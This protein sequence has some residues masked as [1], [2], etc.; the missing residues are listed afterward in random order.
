MPSALRTTR[1]GFF[2]GHCLA[3]LA[4]SSSLA[5]ED[6]SA[7]L[8]ADATTLKRDVEAKLVDLM[9]AHDYAGFAYSIVR[10]R[11]MVVAGGVGVANRAEDIPMTADAV[12]Q[13]GS[14]TKMFTGLL[15]ARLAA[16]DRIEL[17][18]SLSDSWQ[19]DSAVPTDSNERAITLQ[20]LAT[21]TS[22]L[23][24]Y[25]DNLERVDGD[26]ILG[27]SVEELREGLS[28]V[29]IDGELPRPVNYSNF[30]YGVLAE[31]LA[32]SQSSS[33]DELLRQQVIEPLD[34][35]VTDFSLSAEMR[36]RLATPYRD[37]D[38]AVATVPW[39]MG[40]MSAAGGLFS[41]AVDLGRFAVWQLGGSTGAL[42]ERE[43]EAKH[44]QRAPLF[45]YGGTP[46]WAYGLGAF[47]VDDYVG[48]VDVIWHGGDVDGYAGTLVVL[49]DEDL[50]F[51]VLTNVGKGDGFDE[52]QRYLIAR[53]VE[54]C[55]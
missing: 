6:G 4:V 36:R 55:R 3:V 18:D 15:L 11:G 33:F 34:L 12:F 41:S 42:G 45:R 54:L 29:S 52:L 53:A 40:A 44:L 46:N 19:T 10:A 22:G 27:Y 13:I 50:A 25:P 16:E 14:I 9:T 8:C 38:A 5:A 28:A 24:R 7:P 30:G 17:G 49:P 51:A 47:V 1:H 2:L 20:M 23:P 31:A 35:G 32:Q 43:M 21:H 39:D 26:P 48:D 37:D